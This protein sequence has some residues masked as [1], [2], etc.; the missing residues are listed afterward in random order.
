MKREKKSGARAQDEAKL[1]QRGGCSIFLS[2]I[3]CTTE[4]IIIKMKTKRKKKN[5]K[6][7]MGK[8]YNDESILT[9]C[10]SRREHDFRATHILRER[11]V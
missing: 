9:R 8:K 10:T 1:V 5:N 4:I 2:K 7:K 11:V 3:S 6:K